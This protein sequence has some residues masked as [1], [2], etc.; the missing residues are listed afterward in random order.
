LGGRSHFELNLAAHSL[1]FWG[2]QVFFKDCGAPLRWCLDIQ[3]LEIEV[4]NGRIL[5]EILIIIIVLG[6]SDFLVVESLKFRK[7]FRI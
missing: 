7:L 6:G 1:V 5:P 3:G 2:Y 4:W